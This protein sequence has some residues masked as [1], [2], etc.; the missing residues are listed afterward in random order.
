MI[1]PRP[2]RNLVGDQPVGRMR[3]RNAQQRLR[4]T[5]EDHAFGGR[6]VV[7]AQKRIQARS[8]WSR[9][10]HGLNECEPARLYR[11]GIGRAEPRTLRKRAHD[12][13]LGGEKCGIYC[14]ADRGG[15]RNVVRHYKTHRARR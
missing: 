5:H 6:Q 12:R 3:I 14:G 13:L 1:L 15:K 9:R 10:A 7:L 11:R 4:Q 8:G 2:G